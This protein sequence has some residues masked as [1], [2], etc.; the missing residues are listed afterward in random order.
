M[1]LQGWGDVALGRVCLCMFVHAHACV[2]VCA[3]ACVYMWLMWG[4]IPDHLPPY[5]LLTQR[6]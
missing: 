4:V 5:E 6:I 1:T 2:L 3:C